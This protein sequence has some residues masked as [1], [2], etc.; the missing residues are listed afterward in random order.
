MAYCGCCTRRV[1]IILFSVS[2]LILLITGLLLTASHVIIKSRVKEDVQLKPGSSVFNEWKNTSIPF[3]KKFYIFNLTNPEEVMAGSAT[4]SVEQIGPYSYREIR[5][6]KVLEW[7]DDDSIVKFMPNRTYIFDPETSCVGC[8]DRN[9]TF[10]NVNIPLLTLALWL[11]NTNYTM[12]QPPLCS[13]GI[14]A[15]LNKYNLKL[16]R[17]KVVYDI[18]WGYQDEFLEFLL[19]ISSL[20]KCPAKEGITTFIQLQYNNTFYGVSAVNTGRTDISKLEQFTMW[21][22]ESHLSWWSDKYAN[23]LNGTDGTQFAPDV[24]KENK[25]YVFSPEIC[26]SVYFKYEQEVTLKD[27]KLYR[28]TVPDNVFKSGDVYPPN[29]GFCV[30]PGCLPSGLLNISLCQPMNP[31]VVASPPHFYQSDKSLLE[32]VHGLKPEKSK[33]ETFLEI[34]P[35]TGVVMRGAQ[36]VQINIALE[37]VDVLTQTKGSFEKVFLPFMFASETAEITDEKAS[38]FRKKVYTAITLANVFQYGLIILGAFFIVMVLLLPCFNTDDKKGEEDG[39]EDEEGEKHPLLDSTKKTSF[40]HNT[41]TTQQ[42]EST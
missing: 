30:T 5:S 3:F 4:P 31:P 11:R 39:T 23:M 29:K 41:H 26:R 35:I 9:D 27:I 22:N 15:A 17:R 25:F 37:S 14:Q 6:N 12:E 20:S 10:V 34:E 38:D 28:V 2:G 40:S 32:K 33:H 21:R 36:R 13:Y 8:D 1:F 42:G 16:F 19:N 24:D 7:T 18:L